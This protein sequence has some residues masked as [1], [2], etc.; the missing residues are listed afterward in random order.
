MGKRLALCL[1]QRLLKPIR[2]H[3]KMSYRRFFYDL[4]IAYISLV[5]KMVTILYIYI[6]EMKY[7]PCKIIAELLAKLVSVN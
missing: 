3:D 5:Y 7:K 6:Y 1:L 4:H 2:L